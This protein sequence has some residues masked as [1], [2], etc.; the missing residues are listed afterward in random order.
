MPLSVTDHALSEAKEIA[1]RLAGRTAVDLTPEEILE[2]PHIFVGSLAS[3]EAK[4]I[5]LREELGISSV[6]VGE[7]GPL[8]T[9]VE[10][11]AGT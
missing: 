3:L 6:M 4:L 1:A 8:D 7:V 9:I 11:L 2:S 5:R 10:R